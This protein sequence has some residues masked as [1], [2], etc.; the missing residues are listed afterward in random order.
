MSRIVLGYSC[1]PHSVNNYAKALATTNKEK[2]REKVKIG[3]KV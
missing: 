2:V 1:Y 3:M